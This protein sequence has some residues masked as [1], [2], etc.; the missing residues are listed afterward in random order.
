MLVGVD[1]A[2]LEI[3]PSA[4]GRQ[5]TALLII[6]GVIFILMIERKE[7]VEIHHSP[8]GAQVDHAT[9]SGSRNVGRRAFK[10]GRLHLAGYRSQPDQVVEL[11]LIG[12]ETRSHLRWAAA[13]I[14]RA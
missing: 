5:T 10:L 8:S 14:R 4:H 2:L 12:I 11:G 3:F 6:G 9:G 13:E 1:F 7:A